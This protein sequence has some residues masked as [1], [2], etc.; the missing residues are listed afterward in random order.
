MLLADRLIDE[1]LRRGKILDIGCGTYPVFLDSVRFRH[2]YALDKLPPPVTMNAID[3]RS[4]HID[5]RHSLP[6]DDGFFQ[7]VTLLAVLEHMNVKV[8]R[9]LLNEIYRILAPSGAVIVT[10]PHRRGDGL[11]RLLAKLNL[12]SSEEINEHVQQYSPN[13]LRYQLTYA[14]FAESDI[15]IGIFEAGFNIFA[16]VIKSSKYQIK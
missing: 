2:K 3:Y 16:R 10:V 7:T 13:Y 9:Y 15:T 1:N 12:V 14:G 8:A 11:L 5:G 6:Y 4:F